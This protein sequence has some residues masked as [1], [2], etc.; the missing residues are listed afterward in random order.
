MQNIQQHIEALIFSSTGSI[1]PEEI[2]Q[3]LEK[4][5]QQTFSLEETE[6]LLEKII[7]KYNSD[8]FPF[9]VEK[10]NMGYKFYTKE[11]Y[12]QIVKTQINI[13]EKKKLSAAALETLAII[14]YKQPVTK[15]DIEN[16]R[17]VSADYTIHKL[18]E[19]ELISIKGRSDSPGRPVLY[20]TS[21]VFLEHFGINGPE[22]LPKLKELEP[23]ESTS[24]AT[25]MSDFDVNKN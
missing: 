5:F 2:L 24:Q 14:A 21:E 18:L 6:L 20:A 15:S 13:K 3:A 9:S 23:S 8:E 19:K 16:I 25:D 10:V 17:G 12:Y 22:D 4:C 1:S 11:P 7:T